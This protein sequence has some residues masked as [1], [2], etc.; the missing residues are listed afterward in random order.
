MANAKVG[1]WT[2]SWTTSIHLPS[3]KFTSLSPI[4]ILPSILY[5]AHFRCTYFPEYFV[6][7]YL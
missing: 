3:S 1:D 2:Q 5:L 4:L 7:Q 6:S